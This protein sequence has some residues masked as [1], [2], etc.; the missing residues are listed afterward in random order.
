MTSNLTLAKWLYKN[1]PEIYK[2]YRIETVTRRREKARLY[3]RGLYSK[4][5]TP[6]QDQDKEV[7][8]D[9]AL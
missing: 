4:S 2:Q 1:Y 3:M 8:P 7:P 6:K 5:K 9:F